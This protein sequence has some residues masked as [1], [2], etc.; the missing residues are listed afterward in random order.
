MHLSTILK[1]YHTL[2]HS[3]GVSKKR[4]LETIA[5]FIA[6]EAYGVTA[7]DVFMRLIQRERLG[8]TG[9]GNGIAI[10]HCRIPNLTQVVGALVTLDDAIDF[11][12]IDDQPVDLIFVLLV[13][14]ESFN[15]HLETLATLAGLFNEEAFCQALRQAGTSE[16]LYSAAVNFAEA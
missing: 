1:P 2:C 3:P 7:E 10:P 8:S 16:Q 15:E 9:I 13:P 6:H 11:E 14:E 5:N 4:C 12:A